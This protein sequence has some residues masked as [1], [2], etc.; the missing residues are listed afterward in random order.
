MMPHKLYEEIVF[1][2]QKIKTSFFDRKNLETIIIFKL[3][4][5]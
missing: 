5:V 2:N 1:F 3:F 4:G